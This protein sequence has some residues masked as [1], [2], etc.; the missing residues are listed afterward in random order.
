VQN[1]DNWK[2]PIRFV[3]ML[4]AEETAIVQ[5]AVPHFTG[6]PCDIEHHEVTG[7]TVVQAAGYYNCIG[8]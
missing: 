3:G 4:S 5:H 6:G 7:L 1:Q 8:S 2:F